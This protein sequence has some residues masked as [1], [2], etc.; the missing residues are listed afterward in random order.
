MHRNLQVLHDP[1]RKTDT[2]IADLGESAIGRVALVDSGFWWIILLCA[3]TVHLGSHASRH[4]RLSKRNEANFDLV[5]RWWIRY[6]PNSAMRRWLLY[7][8]SSDGKW[9]WSSC[10]DISLFWNTFISRSITTLN[11]CLYHRFC[12]FFLPNSKGANNYSESI[13]WWGIDPLWVLNKPK[14]IIM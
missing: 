11:Y 7:G 6:F 1:V 13:V 9:L 10:D 4:S 2:M 12:L 3:Y 8:G 14:F 5:S